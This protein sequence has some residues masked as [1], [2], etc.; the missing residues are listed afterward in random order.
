MT[1]ATGTDGPYTPPT[2]HNAL[3]PGGFPTA[4]YARPPRFQGSASGAVN[5]VDWRGSA[6]AVRL[7]NSVERST[8]RADAD[9]P[10]RLVQARPANR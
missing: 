3:A 7:R 6:M 5:A 1:G 8:P 4:A 2:L 10:G 9:D